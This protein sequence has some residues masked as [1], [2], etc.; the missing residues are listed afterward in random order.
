ME[1]EMKKL[2]VILGMLAAATPFF[3][4]AQDALTE[5]ITC[6]SDRG[7][8]SFSLVDVYTKILAGCSCRD[9]SGFSYEIPPQGEHSSEQLELPTEEDCL[10]ELEFCKDAGYWCGN[11]AGRC[12]VEENEEYRC[13]CYDG[14]SEEQ[15][16]SKAG[17]YS[18]AGCKEFLV[19][20]CGTQVPSAKDICT[21]EAK[22][23]I[24]LSYFKI[25]YNTCAETPLFNDESQA[26][27]WPITETMLGRAIANCCLDETVREE[28][29]KAIEC[30]K[31]KKNCNTEECCNSCDFQFYSGDLPESDAASG[32]GDK[33]DGDGSVSPSTDSEVPAEKEESKS[34]GCSMLF[35]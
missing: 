34:D 23:D 13:L 32:E 5:T 16:G 18:E 7:S 26:V 33:A 10:A 29:S 9:G 11:D 4:E 20:M 31:A 12:I 22:F 17:I 35:I 27:E 3:V 6:E 15:T 2:L 1:A 21:D 19:E 25:K 14:I 8:C 24:C 28:Y 30:V